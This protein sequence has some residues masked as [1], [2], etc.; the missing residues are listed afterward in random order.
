MSSPLATPPG[1]ASAWQSQFLRAATRGPPRRRPP[2]PGPPSSWELTDKLLGSLWPVCCL[3]VAGG[4]GC[5][6]QG[7]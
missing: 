7:P 2:P 5:Q 4:P 1:W 3:A 6:R